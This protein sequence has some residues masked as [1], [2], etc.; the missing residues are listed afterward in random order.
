MNSNLWHNRRG[1]Q[2]RRSISFTHM[3]IPKKKPCRAVPSNCRCDGRKACRISWLVW[4]L[5]ARRY[6]PQGENLVAG[7]HLWYEK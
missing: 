7:R 3:S 4:Q 1:S 6:G 5:A 2:R